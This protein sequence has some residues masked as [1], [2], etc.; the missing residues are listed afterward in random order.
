MHTGSFKAQART[1]LTLCREP[2]CRKPY[3]HD[4][5]Y[6]EIDWTHVSILLSSTWKA[7]NS[8]QYFGSL[9][10]FT[11]ASWRRLRALA[12][13]NALAYVLDSFKD[14]DVQADMKHFPFK[15]IEKD[16][17]PNVRVE[18]NGQEKT[19]TP[20]EVSAMILGKMK[21]TAESY[22]G[23]PVRYIPCSCTSDRG[24]LNRS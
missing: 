8:Q 2:G 19:F 22:L 10:T 3:K 13:T 14:K 16:G 6:Q 9:D 24:R 21:E 23:K 7:T 20:E 5:G 15:V 4:L 12:F 17:K 11:C 1:L 18:V